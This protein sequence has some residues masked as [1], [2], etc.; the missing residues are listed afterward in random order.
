ME[1]ELLVGVFE[2][3]LGWSVMTE[4][5]NLLCLGFQEDGL[6]SSLYFFIDYTSIF[7]A[8]FDCL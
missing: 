1:E 2:S 7:T 5:Q 3:I 4:K 6:Q 8:V